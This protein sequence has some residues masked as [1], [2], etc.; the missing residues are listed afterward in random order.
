MFQPIPQVLD[1]YDDGIDIS[2][3]NHE[4]WIGQVHVNAHTLNVELN[5]LLEWN[6]LFVHT[7]ALRKSIKRR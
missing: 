3:W 7:I 2:L 1:N 6:Q 5:P 4:D